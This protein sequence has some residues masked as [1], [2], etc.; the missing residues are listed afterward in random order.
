MKCKP[1]NPNIIGNI[2]LKDDGKKLVTF[3]L[4]KEFRKTSITL[5]K[6]KKE[7][8]YKN[9]FKFSLSGLKKLIFD[10]YFSLIAIFLLYQFMRIEIEIL[11]D[12]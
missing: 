11:K 4:K 1:I 2:K 10:I 3:K 5:I 12:K 7:P 8:I 6:N 9:V